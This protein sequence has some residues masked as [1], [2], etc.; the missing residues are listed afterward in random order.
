M[1]RRPVLPSLFEQL[2]PWTDAMLEA[3]NLVKAVGAP[4]SSH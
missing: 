2:E 4:P 1:D 3:A